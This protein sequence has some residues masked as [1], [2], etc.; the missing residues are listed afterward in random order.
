MP[1]FWSTRALAVLPCSTRAWIA[2]NVQGGVLNV[3]GPRGSKHP[4]VYE[5]ARV[6]VLALLAGGA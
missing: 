1:S 5:R 6:L 2:V 4:A 3:A